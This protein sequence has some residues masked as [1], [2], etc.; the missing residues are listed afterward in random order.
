MATRYV[1]RKQDLAYSESALTG[2]R[3]YVGNQDIYAGSG[4]TFNASTGLYTLKN[5]TK[6]SVGQL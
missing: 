1:W 3:V 6:I 2:Q 5:P 4:Y